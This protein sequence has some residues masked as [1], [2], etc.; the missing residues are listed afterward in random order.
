[1]DPIQSQLIQ[2]S[3]IIFKTHSFKINFKIIALPPD[4]STL[5]SND[6]FE[7][8][9]FHTHTVPTACVTHPHNSITLQMQ[10]T[11]KK[12]THCSSV[13]PSKYNALQGVGHYQTASN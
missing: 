8:V 13:N 10:V 6:Y 5:F 11:N 1:M 2:T 12:A 3:S 4:L 9:C 7:Y